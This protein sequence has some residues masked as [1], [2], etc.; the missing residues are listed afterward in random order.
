MTKPPRYDKP[1]NGRAPRFIRRSHTRT[2]KRQY[3]NVELCTKFSYTMTSCAQNCTNR[4]ARP[5]PHPHCALPSHRCTIVGRRH[6]RSVYTA[7]ARERAPPSAGERCTVYRSAWNHLGCTTAVR[8]VLVAMVR[9]LAS[10]PSRVEKDDAQPT[11]TAAADRQHAEHSAKVV[12]TR[13]L[14]GPAGS[15][16]SFQ[17][18]KVLAPVTFA[19]VSRQTKAAQGQ[20]VY[21]GHVETVAEY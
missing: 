5:Q 16:G 11:Q 3:T 10:A 7:K 14:W 18:S 13:H 12:T 9:A 19:S 17:R 1:P 8:R 21:A 20:I 4:N 15:R 6:P 2:V